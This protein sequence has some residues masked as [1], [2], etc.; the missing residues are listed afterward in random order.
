MLQTRWTRQLR[1]AIAALVAISLLVVSLGGSVPEAEGQ[2]PPGLARALEAKERNASALLARPGVVGV[3]VGLNADGEHVVRIL[4]EHGGVSGLPRALD[5]VPVETVVSGMIMARC[6]MTTDHCDPAPLGVSIG[7]PDVT[8]GT[9][10]ALVTDGEDVFI[11]SNNHVLA[12]VN[13]AMVG[14][15]ILQ[16][17]S[18][19]GGSDPSDTIGTLAESIALSFGNGTNA[20]DAAIALTTHNQVSNVALPWL[21]SGSYGTPTTTP[22]AAATPGM[23]VHKCG[24]T[25]GCTTGTVSS[26]SVDVSVCYET[27]GPR[28][29]VKSAMFTNQIGITD[30]SFS[31]GGDS[32]SLIVNNAADP[33]GL[34]FA[35]SDTMTIANDINVVLNSFSTPLEMFDGNLTPNTAPRIT[36]E[37][38]TG[39]VN[40]ETLYSDVV[41][42][43]DDEGHL[44]TYQLQSGPTGMSVDPESGVIRWVPGASDAGLR[45]VPGLY[46]V[47][48]LA[49]DERGLFTEQTATIEVR[50]AVN[51]TPTVS[52]TAPA[53]GANIT[54]GDRVSLT[55][56]S[57]DSE[58]G[59]LS[60]ALIW[61]SSR[62]G[63]LGFGPTVSDVGL[64]VGTHIITA[65]ATDLGD[66]GIG[67]SAATGSDLITVEVVELGAATVALTDLGSLSQGRTWVGRVQIDL[68]DVNL[69]TWSWSTGG[70]GT[71]TP[72]LLPCIVETGGLRKNIGSATLNIVVDPSNSD[73]PRQITVTK[74]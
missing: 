53:T 61:T 29:C 71:C 70:S 7:H 41:A 49:T 62:D 9:L 50:E 19:D 35:G 14:D 16:P 31:A 64:S 44:I 34:L 1:L 68:S 42:A 66:D 23:S 8:A 20:V 10:G 30:G 67:S 43:T 12:N 27:R 72:L 38:D 46:D 24:R 48:V 22:V 25:T 45:G 32:G 52:I 21:D 37:L 59:P 63:S 15:N 54:E 6:Q 26:I 18:L 60:A 51:A 3:G 56:T 73:G 74:P 4:L 17:G 47:T 33:V 13:D 69:V 39:P 57:T 58:D 55:G 40:E 36:S 28:R 5:R 11:L 2:E 65:S